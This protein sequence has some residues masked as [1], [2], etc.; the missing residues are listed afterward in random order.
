MA[1]SILSAI[2]SPAIAGEM[3]SAAHGQGSNVAHSATVIVITV[4]YVTIPF[5]TFLWITM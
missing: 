3:N 1:G 2:L 4:V 5:G